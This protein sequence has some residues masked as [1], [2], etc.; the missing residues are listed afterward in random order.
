MKVLELHIQNDDDHAAPGAPQLEL[1]MDSALRQAGQETG[2]EITLK[3]VDEAEMQDLNHRY[4][5]VSRPTNVLSFSANLPPQLG[6]PLLG[7]IVVCAP[8]VAKEA[9]EQGKPVQAHWAHLVVHGTLHLLGHD[10]V[11]DA[12][13]LRMEHLET[14]TL[15]KLGFADPYAALISDSERPAAS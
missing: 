14:V 3:I 13:A 7:D 15:H 10:H 9:R 4:R 2:A 11:D 1:W 12:E 6:L 5:S 8:L